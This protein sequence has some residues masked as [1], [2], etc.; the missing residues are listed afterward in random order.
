MPDIND[1]LEKQRQYFES[2]A[3]KDAS[4]RVEKLKILKQAILKHEE[5]ILNALEE[6]LGKAGFES[7]ETEIGMVLEE[8]KYT[9]ANLPSWVKPKKVKTPIMHFKSWSHIYPEAYGLALIM[10]PWNYPFQLCMAPLVGAISGGNCSII[11]PSNYSKATSNIIAKIIEE[12]FDEKYIAVVQGGRKENSELLDKKFDIIFFTG[13]VAVGKIVMEAASKHLTPVV[14]ELGGKSPCIVDKESNIDLAARRIVWGKF[15]NAGQTCVAP[16]Y[17][18]VDRSVKDQLLSCMA[19]YIKEFYG[20]N[21][22]E[23]SDLPRII[24]QKHFE[25]LKGLLN[26]GKI[27]VGGTFNEERLRIAPTII[28][29]VTWEDPIMQQEIF[30]PLMPVIEYGDLSEVISMVNKRPKP[31]ALYFFTNNKENEKKIIDSISFGGGCINDTIVHLAT[32]YMPFGG[33]GESGM[34]GYHGKASFDTFTH[35]KSILKKS[36]SLDIKLRYPPYGDNLKKL[37]KF[38]K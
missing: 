11:K 24:N 9:I 34:G 38:F 33:V 14:L 29:E 3:T 12:N 22:C 18:L 30:G 21:P 6:D 1:I 35:Y 5:D 2:G 27:I 10:S 37:K 23:K 17:L 16:D 31:L 25:R 19:K 7:Y 28:D 8:I 13:S 15:L 20:E 32:S 26:K 36:N 4:F